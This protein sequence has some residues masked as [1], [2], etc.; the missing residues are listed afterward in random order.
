MAAPLVV[1]RPEDHQGDDR[2]DEDCGQPVRRAGRPIVEQRPEL[3]GL[4]VVGRR[5]PLREEARPL[6]RLAAEPAEHSGGNQQPERGVDPAGAVADVLEVDES[7]AER[8]DDED[9]DP[10]KRDAHPGDAEQQ[11][12]LARPSAASRCLECDGRDDRPGDEG[13]RPVEVEEK[14][15]ILGR[16]DHGPS[17]AQGAQ[18]TGAVTDYRL[19]ER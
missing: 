1:L 13:E 17:I 12:D 6:R 14:G 7:E 2:D 5:E 4:G 15:P 16:R 19:Q 3:A 8:H 10:D 18:V 11:R 9:A